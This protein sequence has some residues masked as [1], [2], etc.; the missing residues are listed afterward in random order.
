MMENP[1]EKL[2]RM[3]LMADGKTGTWDLSTHDKQAIVLALDEINRK[4][5]LLAMMIEE[6]DDALSSLQRIQDL[7]DDDDFH[8]PQRDPSASLWLNLKIIIGAA[9]AYMHQWRDEQK[10]AETAERQL[11]EAMATIMDITSITDPYTDV[12]RGKKQ[13]SIQNRV[14]RLIELWETAERERAALKKR[15]EDQP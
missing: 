10:R 14:S 1:K 8:L 4:N 15:L 3:E 12:L 5:A 9:H 6:R 7:I 2:S 11:N 13:D